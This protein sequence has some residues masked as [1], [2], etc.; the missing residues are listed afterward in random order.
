VVA[1]VVRSLVEPSTVD[2]DPRQVA[3]DASASDSAPESWAHDAGCPADIARSRA[4]GLGTPNG[5]DPE[6]RC[7]I[8]ILVDCTCARRP[9]RRGHGHFDDT[10][11]VRTRASSG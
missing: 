3:P 2:H 8:R 5:R 11:P 10:V 7:V 6:L 9:N 4:H 1:A